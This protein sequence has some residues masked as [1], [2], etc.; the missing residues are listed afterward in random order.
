MPSSLVT[1]EYTNAIGGSITQG[2]VVR[3]LRL[4]EY[5]GLSRPVREYQYW[6]VTGTIK[7]TID[8]RDFAL[9]GRSS[10]AS[11][12]CPVHHTLTY[13]NPTV[14]W[15]NADGTPRNDIRSVYAESLFPRN[16]SSGRFSVSVNS[17]YRYTYMGR[18]VITD[19]SGNPAYQYISSTNLNMFRPA[20]DIGSRLEVYYAYVYSYVIQIQLIGYDSFFNLLRSGFSFANYF[21]QIRGSY[22]GGTL[23]VNFKNFGV[24]NE[25]LDNLSR[26]QATL[27]IINPTGSARKNSHY[28]L[29]QASDIGF[30]QRGDL[31]P[32]TKRRLDAIQLNRGLSLV[33][34]IR[35]EVNSISQ[36]YLG[37]RPPISIYEARPFVSS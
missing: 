24:R 2:Q 23:S 36:N 19:S 4:R 35:S 32:P 16:V 26:S 6:K 5:P 11:I 28:I 3:N 25:I 22:G 18:N 34:T 12:V 13:E 10:S 29:G 31:D 8:V 20:G 30:Y 9:R 37:S 27:S 21:N 15:A 14:Q 33:D 17:T 1:K 7:N